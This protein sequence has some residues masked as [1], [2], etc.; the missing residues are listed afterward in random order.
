MR[1]R[2]GLLA[3]L[4]GVLIFVT[5]LSITHQALAAETTP[6]SIS[7]F[8]PAHNTRSTELQPRVHA[9]VTDSESGVNSSNI[10]V[11][12]GRDTNKDGVI[13]VQTIDV[14]AAADITAIT[15]GYN[16]SQRISVT[17]TTDQA[18]YWWVKATDLEGN[19]A[20]ADR[21]P[22]ISGGANPC[23]AVSF[24]A[25][26]LV[27]MVPSNSTSV[28]GCQPHVII[29][30]RTGPFLA[31]ATTGSWWDTSKATAD[32]TGFDPTKA[33]RTSIRVDFNEAI[34]GTSVAPS[35][36]R[37][38]G[39]VPSAAEHFPGR[40]QS[41]FLTVAALAADARPR[42]EV[43]GFGV[44]IKDLIGNELFTPH[45]I[46]PST[47]GIAPG[48]TLTVGS[49]VRPVTNGSMPIRLETDENVALGSVSI[50]VVKVLDNTRNFATST[51]SLSFT[52]G[53]KVFLATSTPSVSGLYNV[54]AQASDLNSSTNIGKAGLAA[55]TSTALDLSQA[56]LFEVDTALSTPTFT[57]NTTGTVTTTV[58]FSNEGLEYGLDG[59]GMHTTL[60]AAVVTD[61]DTH[62]TVIPVLVTLDGNDIT[63]ALTSTD[64]VIF[65]HT[66]SGLSPGNHTL[67]FTARDD[68]G[69]QATFVHSFVTSGS[70]PPSVP[71]PHAWTLVGLGLTFAVLTTWRMSKLP[72]GS[73]L[74]STLEAS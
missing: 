52:G 56:V 5:L 44:I 13:D 39:V 9:D 71:G 40:P 51:T 65:R 36:F 70:P 43:V 4:S 33:K 35:D 11:L 60:S 48:L 50:G 22:I 21:E 14:V 15:N 8:S 41:V 61:F 10:R 16:V 58:D 64:G 25:T 12:W 17:L 20:I 27:G 18:V 66:A 34:D 23:D 28:L 30:D 67:S 24:A 38:A 57:V 72:R 1:E 45:A 2:L 3:I 62:G 54:S 26:S 49:S 6:P 55:S 29:I 68:A 32:K 19:I 63:P 73:Q 42:V 74:R 37:V 59:V 47:D 69:N 53:P 31:T 7:N 46:D